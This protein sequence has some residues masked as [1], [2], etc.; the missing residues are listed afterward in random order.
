MG[1]G[2]SKD[3]RDPLESLAQG[4]QRSSQ[5]SP[6]RSVKDFALSETA[7]QC[8]DERLDSVS[9]AMHR[10]WGLLCASGLASM[11]FVLPESISTGAQRSFVD[12]F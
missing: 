1:A 6:R 10:R 11:L 8:L 4:L 3:P 5:R 9:H 2:H 7:R 12:G